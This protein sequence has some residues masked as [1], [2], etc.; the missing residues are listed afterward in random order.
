M[1]DM[2]AAIPTPRKVPV[3]RQVY[4]ARWDYMYV[5]P[6]LIVML[7]VIAYPVWFTIDMSFYKTPPSL[8]LRDRQFVGLRN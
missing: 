4:L 2:T 8:Q 3:F 1:T 5:A 6:A 7:I